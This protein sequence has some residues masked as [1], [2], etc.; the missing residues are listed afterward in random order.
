MSDHSRL[1]LV[2]LQILVLS[3]MATLL[4]RLWFL[5]VV[6][7]EEYQR[8]AASNTGRKLVTP[9]PRGFIYDARGVPLVQNEVSLVVSVTRTTL[10]RER[11]RVREGDRQLLA[12]V[13]TVIGKPVE[14]LWGRTRLCGT[15]QAPEPPVCWNGS[16]QQPIPLTDDADPQMALQIMEREEEFRGVTTELA[17]IRAYPDPKVN[18]AHVFGYVGPVTEEEAAASKNSLAAGKAEVELRT[19]DLSGKSGLERQYDPFLRG[20]PGVRELAVDKNGS[21]TGLLSDTAP[22]A[23]AHL[24]TSIDAR[25]QASAEKHLAEAIQRARE[26]G[27]YNKQFAKRKADAAAV[28]VMDVKT[29][30]ILG[31]ASYP[32]YDPEVWVGGIGPK[33]YAAITGE[34]N[35]FPNINRA[36]SGDFVAAS[37]FKLLTLPAAIQAGVADPKQSYSC[38]G[39]LTFDGRAYSNYEG[40]G[41]GDLTLPMIVAKSCDTAFYRWAYQLWQRDGG[42]QGSSDAKEHMAKMA[43]A[44]GLGKRTGI[45][46]PGERM[47]RIVTRES[48]RRLWEATKEKACKRAEAGYTELAKTNPKHAAYVRRLDHEYCLDGYVFRGGDAINFAIGQGDVSVTPL[49][50]ARAY[51]TIANG[52]NLIVPQ[53]ARAAIGPDGRVLQA[54]PPRTDGKVPVEAETLKFLRD[55]LQLTTEEGTGYGPFVRRFNEGK[56]W[57]LAELPIAS[58][59]GTG[60]ASPNRDG[61]PRD[62][63]SWYASYAPANDPQIAVVMTVSQGGTGSGTSGPSVRDIYADLFGVQADGSIDPNKAIYPDRKPLRD[64]PARDADGNFVPPEKDGPTRPVIPW[65]PRDPEGQEGSKPARKKPSAPTPPPVAPTAFGPVADRPSRWEP[66]A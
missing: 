64:L 11:K 12:R 38:P 21:V 26:E 48:K 58:K 4:G 62:T 59:T 28:V 44:F 60:E 25:V 65:R 51:S 53:I 56:G 8:S 55:S 52:G 2:V 36:T 27:D 20:T 16:P 15:P 9:A 43:L 7:A 3:L 18:G 34:A 39:S 24:L 6:K 17:P 31:M 30:A 50:M 54:F 33:N 63:T 23:G 35:N 66:A 14:E 29:G 22:V 1:R 61:T 49:Q 37:T 57:P 47:G 5:Q 19:T 13:A 42:K 40:K 41:E 10:E 46:L 32:T 45:D